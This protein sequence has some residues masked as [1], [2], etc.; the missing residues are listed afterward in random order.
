MSNKNSP[1]K[2]DKC[3]ASLSDAYVRYLSL[4][5]PRDADPLTLSIQD[6]HFKGR[7]S[8]QFE[9]L[10]VGDGTGYREAYVR[11]DDGQ[12]VWIKITDLCVV[13][14]DIRKVQK[15]GLIRM[16]KTSLMGCVAH[17]IKSGR[18]FRGR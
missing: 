18:A 14:G 10:Q 3:Y 1:K 4:C 17:S 11:L 8:E 15:R 9:V 13:S 7:E 2:D 6:V 16:G 5:V 12:E